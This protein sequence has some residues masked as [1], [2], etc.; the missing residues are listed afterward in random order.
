MHFYCINNYNAINIFMAMMIGSRVSISPS[1]GREKRTEITIISRK[2]SKG[3]HTFN[4]RREME[5]DINM[6]G[7]VYFDYFGR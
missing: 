4:E 2:Y 3:L 5:Y 7:E 1:W 6:L